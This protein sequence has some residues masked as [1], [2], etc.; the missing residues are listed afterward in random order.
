[1]TKD[2]NKIEKLLTPKENKNIYFFIEKY[3][4][5]N[6]Y[7]RCNV[8]KDFSFDVT[9]NNHTDKYRTHNIDLYFN[10][11]L[12]VIENNSSKITEYEL[13]DSEFLIVKNKLSLG[14]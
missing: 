11:N 5:Y 6:R 3:D 13:I 12:I 1:M 7:V 2:L 9:N 10:K 8:P 4:N 14:I